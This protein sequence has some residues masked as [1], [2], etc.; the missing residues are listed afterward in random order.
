MDISDDPAPWFLPDPLASLSNPDF[1]ET[2]F[3]HTQLAVIE[4]YLERFPRD[5]REIRALAWIE[6]NA[7]AYRQH[8]Q[9]RASRGVFAQSASGR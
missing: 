6:A 4:A 7:G 1:S 2:N 3:L 9:T 5:E 8:W